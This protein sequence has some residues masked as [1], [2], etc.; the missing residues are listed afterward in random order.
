MKAG[1]VAYVGEVDF[2]GGVWV[3]V[4]LDEAVGKNDGSM[5]GVQYFQCEPLHGIFFPLE[6]SKELHKPV[7]SNFKVM[8]F[9]DC[10]INEKNNE[11]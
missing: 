4:I 1:I 9:I 5:N 2:S 6:Q 7:S 3:G 10:F 11:I 8:S